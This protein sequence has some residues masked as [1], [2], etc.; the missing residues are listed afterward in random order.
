MNQAVFTALFLRFFLLAILCL[1][2]LVRCTFCLEVVSAVFFHPHVDQLSAV[3]AKLFDH[4]GNPVHL[5]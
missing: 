2:R 1:R 5:I 4:L 3:D